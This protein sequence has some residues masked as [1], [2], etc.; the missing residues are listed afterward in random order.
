VNEVPALALI[1]PHK[2]NP[3]LIMNP[4]PE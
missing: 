3:E 1:H 2:M 4:S